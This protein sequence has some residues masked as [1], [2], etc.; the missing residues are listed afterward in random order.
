M[1]RYCHAL[2][3]TPRSAH[4]ARKAYV[5]RLIDAGINIDRV[6]RQAGHKSERTTLG[7]YC[8]DRLDDT[9]NIALLQQSEPTLP[10]V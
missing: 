2:G 9:T 3:I 5:S 4:K 6:Q 1:V 10:V 7:S 8:F